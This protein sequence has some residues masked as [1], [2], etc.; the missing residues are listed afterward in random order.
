MIHY[1]YFNVKELKGFTL[2]K[3]YSILDQSMNKMEG[4]DNVFDRNSSYYEL[5]YTGKVDNVFERELISLIRDIKLN[6]LINNYFFNISFILLSLLYLSET[7][8]YL[9]MLFI[10]YLH[11][12]FIFL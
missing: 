10:L 12:N 6:K 8:S 4:I 9:N 3:E 2:G 5:Y 7:N 11:M 1:T